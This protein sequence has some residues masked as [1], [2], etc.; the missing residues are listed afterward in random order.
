[1]KFL[2][3]TDKRAKLYLIAG[4][5][6][7]PVC[8]VALAAGTLLGLKAK[9]FPMALLMVLSALSAYAAPFLLRAFAERRA[10]IQIGNLAH[11]AG[12]M[13]FSE[14]SDSLLLKEDAVRALA[15]KGERWGLYGELTLGECGFLKK[16][17]EEHSE[18]ECN[19]VNEE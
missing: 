15:A 4:I 9:Y 14:I 3:N 5:S 16:P 1:M 18:G 10:A 19:E 11:G 2:E 13:L 8:I 17:S 7:I 6:A 12:L